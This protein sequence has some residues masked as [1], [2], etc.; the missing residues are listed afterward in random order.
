MNWEMDELR[1]GWRVGRKR[2]M[3]AVEIGARTEGE[4]R[5]RP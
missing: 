4:G 5:E 1:K 2:S 3:Q